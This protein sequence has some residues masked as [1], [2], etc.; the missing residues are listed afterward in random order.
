[1][2]SRSRPIAL[3]LLLAFAV[4]AC[5]LALSIHTA[6]SATH[7]SAPGESIRV[8]THLARVERELQSQDVSA[9][10]PAQ[11]RARRTQIVHL[12]EYRLRGR[13]PHNHDFQGRHVPYFADR[14]GTLCAMAHLIEASGRSDIV[15]AVRARSNHARV[16]ELA[17]DPELGPILLAWLKDAG[18]TVAEA[19]RVQPSYEYQP[20]EESLISTGYGV[21]SG[22]LGGVNLVA[23]AVNGGRATGGRGPAWTA[24]VGLAMGGAQVVL[25]ASSLDKEGERRVLGIANV[26]VGL[27]SFVASVL[28]LHPSHSSAS[29]SVPSLRINPT[30]YSLGNGR[31]LGVRATF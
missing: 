17:A 21:A 16:T 7:P 6:R 23:I 13:F 27:A 29:A 18:L 28:A 20:P 31:A 2:F 26:A 3:P 8:E 9:L 1:M 25:G 24:P 12:H 10:T 22:V 11:Q 15:N 5:T 19:Q 30:V 4:T 14:H